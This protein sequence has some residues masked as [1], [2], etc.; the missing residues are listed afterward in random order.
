MGTD[1]PR[2][3]PGRWAVPR[4]TATRLRRLARPAI[5]TPV[6]TKTCTLPPIHHKTL[7]RPSLFTLHPSPFTLHSSLFTLH[8]SLLTIHPSLSGILHTRTFRPR[9]RSSGAV[10]LWR[11]RRM[12]IFSSIGRAARTLRRFRLALIA[13]SKT[14]FIPSIASTGPTDYDAPELR[15]NMADRYPPVQEAA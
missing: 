9:A 6:F 8:S 14:C 10:I 12:R 5:K 7:H 4:G 13:V 1:Q 2:D 11:V 15:T 3:C